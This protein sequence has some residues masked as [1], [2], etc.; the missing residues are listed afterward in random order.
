MHREARRESGVIGEPVGARL[1]QVAAARDRAPGRRSRTR[2]RSG[3]RRRFVLPN[4]ARQR[5]GADAGLIDD[6]GPGEPDGADTADLRGLL[7]GLH[8][9]LRLHTAQED[10]SYLSQHRGGAASHPGGRRGGSCSF[11]P[12]AVVTGLRTSGASSQDR[13]FRPAGGLLVQEPVQP[14][15]VLPML[16]LISPIASRVFTITA[17]HAKLRPDRAVATRR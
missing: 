10:E 3:N 8:A 13:Q 9:I 6:I 11:P 4:C 15:A 17:S 1:V 5:P 2:G 12:P 16:R 7:Y 14:G